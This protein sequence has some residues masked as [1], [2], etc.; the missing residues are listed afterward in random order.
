MALLVHAAGEGE[1]WPGVTALRCP[2]LLQGGEKGRLLMVMQRQ[3]KA[4]LFPGAALGTG[5]CFCNTA[6]R[7]STDPS[8]ST[9][10]PS[11]RLPEVQI[12]ILC[13]QLCSGLEHQSPSIRAPK[14]SFKQSWADASLHAAKGW[15]Y[16]TRGPGERCWC[17]TGMQLSRG[18]P[19]KAWIK[20]TGPGGRSRGQ[21]A[22]EHGIFDILSP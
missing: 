9:P 17:V 20:L 18:N 15:E 3:F 13:Y 16:E 8:S 14:A 6:N 22:S 11:S 21:G 12:C 7:S 4:H 10:A 1:Q 5:R 19:N 2:G